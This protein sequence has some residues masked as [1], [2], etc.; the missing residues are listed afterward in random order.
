MECHRFT[1]HSAAV[2][3]CLSTAAVNCTK[4][5]IGPLTAAE[6]RLVDRARRET[7]ALLRDQTVLEWER[8]T[9]R[10]TTQRRSPYAGR[11]WL[12]RP[13]T[14]NAVHSA[15]SAAA[16]QKDKD[17]LQFLWRFLVGEHLRYAIEDVDGAIEELKDRATVHVG[18][19]KV[20][21]GQLPQWLAREPDP[22]N[23]R[24]ARQ[25]EQAV[26][27]E[28][29][30]LLVQ[31][32]AVQVEVAE[33][34]GL[35][36]RLGLLETLA[37]HNLAKL[38]RLAQHALFASAA[39][40]ES[41]M[42]DLAPGQVGVTFEELGPADLDRLLAIPGFDAYFPKGGELEAVR[43][44]L[45]GLGIP[46]TTLPVRIDATPRDGKEPAAACFPVRMPGDVRLSLTP[47]GGSAN[48]ET[49][50][51]EMG[52][53][54]H[55][56]HTQTSIF[57]FRQL[58]DPAT[59]ETFAVLF[60]S[61]VAKPAWLQEML[62][63]SEPLAVEFARL[64]ALRRLLMLRRH[65]ARTFYELAVTTNPARSRAL[66]RQHLS[67]AY[68]F[69]VDRAEATRYVTERDP[70][71]R[72]G[73]YLRAWLLA[74]H[75]DAEL[76]HRFSSTWWRNSRAGQHLRELWSKDQEG[77][78][79]TLAATWD[80]NGARAEAFLRAAAEAL[81]RQPVVEQQPQLLSEAKR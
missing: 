7:R 81:G 36:D 24:S 23:R 78:G 37:P 38:K 75:L 54:L 71:L 40:F 66:Y 30:P 69:T 31:R 22:S 68:G 80:A 61:L 62:G 6:I 59:A 27:R 29:T 57:E 56:S 52:H 58:G 21:Y 11:G 1:R 34:F 20:P 32:H 14:T 65:A 43:S 79:S 42:R 67:T 46:W 39:L 8:W 25:A 13:A 10:D 26:L 4:P 53:A 2:V 9:G 47:Q 55:F 49:L 18:G 60:S 50:L 33:R 28:L 70:F 44:T 45:V 35:G 51:H 48:Y 17:A 41:A 63:L 64:A 19:D 3:L 77:P 15:M 73:V 72:T 16:T 76:T 5:R 12:L 74:A